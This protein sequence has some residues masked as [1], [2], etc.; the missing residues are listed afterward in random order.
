MQGRTRI[1]FIVSLVLNLF[2]VGAA[3]GALAVGAKMLRDR[4]D[5]R[6]GGRPGMLSAVETI[7]EARRHAIQQMMREQALAA[8]PEIR[9]SRA[10][11]RRAA[12]L[13]AAP[14]YDVAAVSAALKEAR[15]REAAARAKI[16]T[17]IASRLAELSPTERARFGRVMLRGPGLGDRRGYGGGPRRAPAPPEAAPTN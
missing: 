15:D 4:E 7:P 6:R 1:L 12:S 8:A 17:A 2:F 14:S 9:A 10:A 13:I 11:R 3:V 16:D 5:F